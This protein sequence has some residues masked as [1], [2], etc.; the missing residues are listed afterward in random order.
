MSL[1]VR[2]VVLLSLALALSSA[3]GGGGGVGPSAAGTYNLRLKLIATGQKTPYSG[4]A[5]FNLAG[6]HTTIICW[7][8]STF[9]TKVASFVRNLPVTAAGDSFAVWNQATAA[10]NPSS[11]D[12]VFV[13]T[14]VLTS[15]TA[16]PFGGILSITGLTATMLDANF[17]YS[18]G[19]DDVKGTVSAVL[20]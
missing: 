17:Q 5:S 4:P 16:T 15:P 8:D 20:R 14:D 12:T 19:T 9:T 18:D 13:V 2:A 1:P 6:G 10:N 7:T 3:C 11:L